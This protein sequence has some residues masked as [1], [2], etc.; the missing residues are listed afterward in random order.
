MIELMKLVST[1]HISPY[2]LSKQRNKR[3]QEIEARRKLREAFKCKNIFDVT[4]LCLQLSNCDSREQ[5]DHVGWCPNVRP[6]SLRVYPGPLIGH[7]LPM[8]ASDWLVVTWAD[9]AG[10][11]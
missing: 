4:T 2:F 3:F 11:G 6:G 7:R 5:A 8:L 9:Q 1:Y 10:P